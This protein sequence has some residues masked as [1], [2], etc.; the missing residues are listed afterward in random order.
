[1]R[2]IIKIVLPALG[3]FAASIGSAIASV[4]FLPDC[5]MEFEQPKMNQNRDALL[6]KQEGFT[7]QVGTKCPS[8]TK[9]SECSVSPDHYFS[10]NAE[11]WCKENGYQT[12]GESCVKPEYPKDKC[13]SFELYKSCATDIK[14]ACQELNPNFTNNCPSGW[15]VDGNQ[16]CKYDYT[17]GICCNI[18]ADYTTTN[19]TAPTGYKI[20]GSCNSCNGT[21]YK[22]AALACPSGYSTAT[23]S[24]SAGYD[25][26]YNGYS[27]SSKC[28]K[29]TAKSCPS[30]YSTSVASC[31]NGY[32]FQTNGYSGSSV[33]GKCISA[34]CSDGGYYS[35]I[36]NGMTCTSVTYGTNNC[37]NNCKT[38]DWGQ[39]EQACYGN[40]TF[41]EFRQNGELLGIVSGNVV[42][43]NNVP[44]VTRSNCTQDCS[45]S[46]RGSRSWRIPSSNELNALRCA[47]KATGAPTDDVYWYAE[48]TVDGIWLFGTDYS[49]PQW[50]YNDGNNYC[51]C[52][53]DI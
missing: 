24:C 49:G 34:T 45:R 41:K 12:K 38:I 50:M 31:A 16:T 46:N 36:P 15:M 51:A 47:V 2:K 42:V 27:G 40:M 1:M 4:C 7:Y 29:C 23:I 5:N 26:S 20:N 21:K 17:Y 22:L 3:L 53:S 33:C 28:G 14:R 44:Y 6:C 19:P 25:F 43:S 11:A 13:P 39:A 30:G 32:K 52:V 9:R 35:N 10:C 8:N 18:C 48:D 37:Y